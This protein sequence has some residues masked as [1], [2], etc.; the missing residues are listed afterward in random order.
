MTSSPYE[1]YETD[2][3]EEITFSEADDGDAALYRN[4]DDIAIDPTADLELDGDA[5]QNTNA[6]ISA[7]Q[8]GFRARMGKE[9]DR[10]ELVTMSDYYTCLVF[11]TGAHLRA[12]LSATGW[13]RYGEAGGP[14]YL[15]GRKVAAALNIELPPDPE[16]PAVRRDAS[17]DNLGMTVEDNK[18]IKE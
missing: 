4:L 14:Y 9:A 2:G 1:T 8:A 3:F 15:D 13:G 16:W 17:Y 6:E 7:V 18:M 12:F 5:A 10:L 11:P